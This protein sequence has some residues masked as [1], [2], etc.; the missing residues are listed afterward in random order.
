M[1]NKKRHFKIIHKDVFREI[2]K[3]KG[4]FISLFLIVVLGVA[5]YAGIR[6]CGPD[7]LYSADEYYDDYKLMDIRVIST[8]GL[9]DADIR[10]LEKVDGVER[11]YGCYTADLIC[12]VGEE[13][14]TVKLMSITEGVNEIVLKS[15]I[16]P[17][18]NNEC[19]VDEQFMADGGYEIGDEITF[20][21]GDGSELKDTLSESKFVITGTFASPRY[22]SFDLGSTSIGSGSL[23]GLV[24]V[25]ADVFTYEYYTEVDIIAEGAAQLLCYSDE[26]EDLIEEVVENIEDAAPGAEARRYEDILKE[27]QELIEKA[28][29]RLSE[30]QTEAEEELNLAQA[31]LDSY[32]AQANSLLA[33][34][35][36]LVDLIGEIK[37]AVY[38]TADE[39]EDALDEVKEASADLY[40]DVVSGGY[41]GFL[42]SS[43]KQEIADLNESLQEAESQAQA[44]EEIYSSALSLYSALSSNINYYLQTQQD[45]IDEQWDLLEEE[46]AE[47]LEEIEESE[48]ELDDVEEGQWYV[49]DRTYLQ[50]YTGYESDAEKISNIGKVFP[51]IFFIVAALVCLTTMTRMVDEERTQIGT[52]KALGYGK[53]TIISKYIIYALIATLSGSVIGCVIGSVS[54]PLII[55]NVYKLLYDNL[56]YILVP[57]NRN[58]CIVAAA[59]ASGCILIATLAACLKS[60]TEVP[61]N[62]MR[63]ESPKKARK[64]LL[65]R[66]K[67]LWHI[68]PFGWKN[69]LRNF[70]RYKK[71]LFMTLFGICGSTALLL[72]GFGLQD[73]INSI[74][75][76]QYGRIHL[77]D[78]TLTID[79]DSTANDKELLYQTLDF[80]ET[81]GGY[82]SLYLTSTD[83]ESEYMSGHV[84][85]YVYVV[86]DIE[87]FKDFI[88]FEDRLSGESVQMDTDTVILAEKTAD[89]L[90]LEVGDTFTVS[91]DGEDPHTLTVGGIAENYVYNNIFMSEEL[92]EEIY[93]ESPEYNQIL[94]NAAEG[95]E[96]DS[97]E[98]GQT[99]LALG[100]VSAVTNIASAKEGFA[101]M[102]SSLDTITL[103]LIICAGALT[104]IVLFN[105]TNINISERRRELATLKVL[106]FYDLELSQYIYRENLMI[107]VIG[108]AIG[109]FIG[110]YLNNFVITTVEV[111]LVMFGRDIFLSSYIISAALAFGFAVI[112]NIIVHFKLK[113]IDMAA[114]LKSVE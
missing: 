13:S 81:V 68:I 95:Q 104:F 60:L 105:L 107:T 12:E 53:G 8:L 30:T 11:A 103:V 21:T 79:T 45:A 75:D 6:S 70:V 76:I 106:G 4:R 2:K 51:V 74:V 20:T 88:V 16:M 43:A 90:G 55:I 34:F 47:A 93:G 94:I 14:S 22:L 35:A 91:N 84:S 82:I 24:M 62:L 99:Y 92:Y 102:L 89:K 7:M 111:D 54:L 63:P 69:A 78:E 37:D 72:V 77:Y 42:S 50:D 10:T 27:A 15:G 5:F 56:E 113:K 109:L 25:N 52:L 29:T 32:T 87:L 98:F 26:Y 39:Y 40:D 96:I 38:D 57:M 71:R 101:D 64:L 58:H 17:V 41:D 66:I 86:P 48:A 97:D 1:K 18:N 110:R 83:A 67:P 59:L 49:L 23:D 85:C 80:D 61:A 3:S 112:V 9:T 33:E 28:R 36:A 108:I 44:L 46:I 73:S 19:L 100:A 65:E 114:S 31:A